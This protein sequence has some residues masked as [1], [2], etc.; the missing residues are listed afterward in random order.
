MGI[1]PLPAQAAT[2]TITSLS[3][4]STGTAVLCEG[5]VSGGTPAYTYAWN[6]TGR[7]LWNYPDYSMTSI[8]C[9]YGTLQVAFTVRDRLGATA[10]KTTSVT[11]GTRY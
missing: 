10:S 9:G 3:C 4:E 11:C 7:Y 6:P 1:S 5:Y 2:L 8:S